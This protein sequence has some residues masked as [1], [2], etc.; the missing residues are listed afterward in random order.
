MNM[1]TRGVRVRLGPCLEIDN[2]GFR[3]VPVVINVEDH[4]GHIVGWQTR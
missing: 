4:A 3:F 1:W 2:Y